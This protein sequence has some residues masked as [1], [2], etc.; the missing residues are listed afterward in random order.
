MEMRRLIAYI[1]QIIGV[2]GALFFY[3]YEGIA[4]RARE[5]WFV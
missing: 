3:N 4:I 5:A 1:R 2:F